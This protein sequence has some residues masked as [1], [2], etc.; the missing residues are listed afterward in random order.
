MPYDLKN[1]SS[2]PLDVATLAGPAILPAGGELS[3]VELSAYEADVLAH[4][5]YIEISEASGK[6]AEP[7]APAADDNELTKLRADYQEIVGK[8]A[9]HGWSAEELQEKIDAKLAE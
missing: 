8:K 5:P 7:S 3:S 2:F 4:S 1:L 6:R 9:Y